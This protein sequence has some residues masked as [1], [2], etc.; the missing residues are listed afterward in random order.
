MG[1]RR[2]NLHAGKNRNT[3]DLIHAF[4]REGKH[5]RLM[6]AVA[7][8]VALSTGKNAK[9]ISFKQM[10]SERVFK[11]RRQNLGTIKALSTRA[12]VITDKRKSLVCHIEVECKVADSSSSACL[13][14]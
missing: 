6:V 7:P 13:P 8:I 5:K 14:H 3:V 4:Y 12:T 10:S 11:S 1:L 9:Q 2:K